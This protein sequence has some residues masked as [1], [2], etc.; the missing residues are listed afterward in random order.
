MRIVSEGHFRLRNEDKEN[1][2]E[3]VKTRG[4]MSSAFVSAFQDATSRF[5]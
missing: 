4:K 2:E 1:N 3:E 5:L